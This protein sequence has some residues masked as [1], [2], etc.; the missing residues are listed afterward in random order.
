MSKKNIANA[1]PIACADA[2]FREGKCASFTYKPRTVF[3]R[4]AAPQC[5][6]YSKNGTLSAKTRP[7]FLSGSKTPMGK[8]GRSVPGRG[9]SI[10]PVVRPKFTPQARPV[11]KR[12]GGQSIVIPDKIPE[13]S[14][15]LSD[16]D[17]AQFPGEM[18]DPGTF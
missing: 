1:D 11:I 17:D 13:E 16:D 12:P 3:P 10:K 8:T 2:C 4:S 15:S 5:V 14:P 6:I 9:S 7:G 18:L